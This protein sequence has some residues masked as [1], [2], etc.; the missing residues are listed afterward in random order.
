MEQESVALTQVVV[1]LALVYPEVRA[2]AKAVGKAIKIKDQ[3]EVRLPTLR[4][5]GVR[6]KCKLEKIEKMM[7][8]HTKRC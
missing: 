7:K 2:E 8:C 3:G 4:S 5:E 1:G 6:K